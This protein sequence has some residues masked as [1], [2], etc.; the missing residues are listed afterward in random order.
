MDYAMGQLLPNF[1][2]T[3]SLRNEKFEF[4]ICR[5]GKNVGFKKPVKPTKAMVN[6]KFR[7]NF[8]PKAK[9]W[10]TECF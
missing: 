5:S 2:N 4:K 6:S 3:K 10:H 7:I 1:D 8:S 9:S